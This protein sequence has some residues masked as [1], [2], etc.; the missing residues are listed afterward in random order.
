MPGTLAWRGRGGGVGVSDGD[1][2]DVGLLERVV[3]ILH[4]A[5]AGAY[6][7]DAMR[8]L[9][10][11]ARME[12]MAAR[13]SAPLPALARN[14][15]RFMNSPKKG[16]ERDGKC[17]WYSTHFAR[18]AKWMGTRNRSTGAAMQLAVQSGLASVALRPFMLI[19]VEASPTLMPLPGS[20]TRRAS[21]FQD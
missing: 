19:R 1:A 10:P 6:K 21:E 18:S 3:K 7:A 13:A 11:S 14:L 20:G 16:M 15:R 5:I 17:D 4:A 12:G 2:L 9:A 8:S